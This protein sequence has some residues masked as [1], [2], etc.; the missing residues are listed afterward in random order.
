MKHG[1]AQMTETLAPA[2]L[3]T[4]VAVLGKTGAG[5]TMLLRRI[6]EELLD[7]GNRVCTIDPAGA[8]WG[9]RSSADGKGPGYPITVLG[10]EHGDMPLDARHGAAIAEIV[11]TTSTPMI[12]DTR[13][14]TVGERTRF[15]AD[16]AEALL[17]CVRGRLHLVIDE[18]HLFA[19]KGKV[20]DPASAKMLHATN[21]L[22]SLGRG[23]GI[24][25]MLLTQRPAKLHND[26]LTQVETLIAM[27]VLA[28]HDRE[29]IISWIDEQADE[30]QSKEMLKSLSSLRAGEGW[31]WS[32][33]NGIMERRQFPKT[34]TFDSGRPRE[35]IEQ[36]VLAAIDLPVLEA[37]LGTIVQ[38][39]TENDP[40]ALRVKVAV[41]ERQLADAAHQAANGGQATDSA[42]IEKAREEGHQA[43]T[44]AGYR[45]GWREGVTFA[46][47]RLETSAGQIGA[48]LLDLGGAIKSAEP[49]G[50]VLVAPPS[51]GISLPAAVEAPVIERA[52]VPNLIRP[53]RSGDIKPA[54]QRVLDAIAWWR[55][56]GH[57]PVERARAAVVAGYS[58]K[59]STFGVYVADLVQQ[60]LVVTSPGRV[61]LTP[62]GL[63]AAHTP[64]AATRD[65]L[66]DLARSLLSPQEQRVFDVVYRTYPKDIRRDAVAEKV[67][68]SPTASTSGVYIAGVAAYGLIEVSGRGSVRA[69]PWLFQ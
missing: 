38:E 33:L 61:A 11:G 14:M 16:F 25:A 19:P 26:S 59:A 58:P 28:P 67:G 47:Q 24:S 2:I 6:V 51:P 15:F 10:G 49:E 62:A 36:P 4:H 68:L 54:L 31:V 40:K 45:E 43:G 44:Q 18:A 39:A 1:E 52:T 65:E 63:K 35:D 34:R 32:P 64:N 17:R 56:I 48:L 3:D 66:R 9:L 53:P 69:A 22:I 50:R 37:K 30:R 21:N 23:V 29:A 46:A 8:H 7:R 57:A 55:K 42:A 27:R 12:L 5:K 41:L 13:K 20:A 60:G